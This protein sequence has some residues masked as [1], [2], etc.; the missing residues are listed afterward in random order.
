[1]KKKLVI[2]LT[3]TNAS[4]KG[5]VANYFKKKHFTYHSLS[6]IIRESA[7]KSGMEPTRENLISLGNKLRKRYGPAVLARRVKKNLTG[8]DIVD[9]IRNIA[10]IKELKKL[11]NFVLLGIDAPVSLRFKR[12]LKRKRAGDDKSLRE[13][14][15]KENRERS[16]FRTHQQLELCL[17][18]ADKKLINN[19]SIK[20]LQK[21]VER[22]LKSI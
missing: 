10:E 11:P 22:T 13:F 6:D 7:E 18:K 8:K 4:G 9:S 14:I 2:G 15:L 21:K 3:G 12:S 19:G 5:E 17:K 1:M 16:T 20:E